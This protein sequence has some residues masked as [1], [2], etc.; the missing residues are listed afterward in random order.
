MKMIRSYTIGLVLMLLG[1]TMLLLACSN[2]LEN[3]LGIQTNKDK[4]APDEDKEP[5]EKPEPGKD[6]MPKVLADI[7]KSNNIPGVQIAHFKGDKVDSYVYGVTDIASGTPLTDEHLFQAASIS[8]IVATYAFLRLYEK[9]LFDLDE[10]LNKYFIYDRVARANN[11]K[12]DLITARHVLA[13]LTGYPNWVTSAYSLA[14]RTSILE[15]GATYTPGVHYRYS[16][17]GFTYLQEVIKHLTGKSLQQIAKEEVFDPFGMTSTSYQWDPKFEG[18]NTVGHTNTDGVVRMIGGNGMTEFTEQSANS[19]YSMFTNARDFVKFLKNGLVDGKGLKPE[20][21]KLLTTTVSWSNGVNNPNL[22]R[23]LGLVIQHNERGLSL[24]H[25]GSNPG[26]LAY[27]IAY[28]D[29]DEGL[30]I[31]TNHND[32]GRFMG[33]SGFPYFLGEDQTFYMFN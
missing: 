24:Y 23:G 26:Y 29:L 28:P 13:H 10:P 32:A 4:Y 22:S 6:R 5:G 21:Y 31:F 8:K 19:A 9:G 7:A 16:G 30:V 27:C 25:S 12:N 17:E 20:T 15:P 3:E 14:W 18:K 2:R 11:P 33:R 1:Q